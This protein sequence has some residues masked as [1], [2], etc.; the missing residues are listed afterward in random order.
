MLEGDS[1]SSS[2]WSRINSLSLCTIVKN[3]PTSFKI[4]MIFE[5]KTFIDSYVITLSDLDPEVKIVSNYITTSIIKLAHW[6]MPHWCE[7]R[8]QDGYYVHA[9]ILITTFPMTLTYYRELWCLR[10]MQ[11]FY[12][13]IWGICK[14]LYEITTIL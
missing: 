11:C 13:D 14:W 5:L 9:H 8:C 7:R 3:R 6:V 2:S 10:G 4:K 12:Y 1:A